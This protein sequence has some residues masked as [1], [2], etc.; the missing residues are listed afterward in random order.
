MA[1]FLIGAKPSEM[2]E[3]DSLVSPDRFEG[4][5][6]D[7]LLTHYWP[8]MQQTRLRAERS[9]TVIAGEDE[10]VLPETF[11]I[12]GADQY[13]AEIPHPRT[14]PQRVLQKVIARRP[15]LSIPLGP[16][17]LGI[18]G[19][20][21]TT[22][23]EEP[24]NAICAD[25][26][27][28]FRWEPTCANL[29][30]EG[31]CASVTV[32]DPADWVKH[33]SAWDD[34]KTRTWKARYRVDGS[35]RP[36]EDQSQVDATRARRLH[37]LDL[38]IFRARHV[39]IR[40]RA[41]SIRNCAPIFGPDLTVEGLIISQEF[42]ASYLRRHYRFGD[43]GVAT[44]TGGNT[45]GDS[46]STNAAMGGQ[47]LTLIEGW[48]Y[49]EDGLPYCSYAVK[50][51]QTVAAQWK[52]DDS[53]YDGKIAT[54]SLKDRF[55]LD[56]LP[57]AWEWGLGNPA[58]TNPDRRAMGFLEPF[59]GGWR[60]VRAKMTANNVA[61]MFGSYPILLEE[62]QAGAPPGSIEDDQPTKPDIMP[63]KITST[64]PGTTLKQLEIRPVNDA[65]YRQIEL[66]LGAVTDQSP[67]QSN[68]DQS[69]FSQSMAEAF[70]EL[71]LTTVHEGLGRLY[72]THGSFV[73]EAGKRLPEHGRDPER[74]GSGYAPIMVFASSD[75]P[76]GDGA[77][78][79]HNEPMT[80]DPDLIDETFTCVATYVKAM[81]IPETQQSME[82]V[83][84]NLKTRRKH[85][86]DTGDTSPET[87]ELELKLESVRASPEYQK[88]LLG[89]MA[90]VQGKEEL[91]AIGKAQDDGLSDGDGLP[92]GLE[93]GV[94]PAPP[95][96]MP[97]PMPEGAPG[98]P[99]GGSTTGMAPPNYGA[100]SL[101]GVVGGAGMTG[102]ISRAG[103]AGGVI[104]PN[105]PTPNGMG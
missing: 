2:A 69:G 93:H 65:A 78:E 11:A 14:V 31:F 8:T 36:T 89:L 83:A 1:G 24:L 101:A 46:L 30:F 90:E 45:M 66:E 85:L 68:K 18:T 15:R 99:V 26:A 80:L 43:T 19:Q 44:P 75:V 100:A 79:R 50:G 42:S 27:A 92:N 61:I 105:L 70:E 77:D 98:V 38:D 103:A 10:F 41:I 58:E 33:P 63:L 71:A 21:L 88:Y 49:D 87:T 81:S 86:E 102:P 29:L 54:L 60:S 76:M 22:R 25:R 34:E 94:A 17:G 28:G 32:L 6:L 96:G 67:G 20:R 5:Q 52:G 64:R 13:V 95:P 12:A 57:V 53:S 97:P 39:P 37:E 51:V 16:K 40:H 56:R 4:A 7:E 73:L 72:E 47:T 48:F 82:E 62:S 84:R 35:G 9:N 74:P 91:K 59:I 23:V 3:R 55:G 104:P